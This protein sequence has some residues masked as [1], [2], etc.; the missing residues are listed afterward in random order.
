[1][2][3]LREIFIPILKLLKEKIVFKNTKS[4]AKI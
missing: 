1:M 4:L 3:I 2:P